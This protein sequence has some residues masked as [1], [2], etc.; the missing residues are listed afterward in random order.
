MCLVGSW[1]LDII[2]SFMDSLTLP[3]RL[4]LVDYVVQSTPPSEWTR[5]ISSDTFHGGVVQ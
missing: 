1:N 5:A 2:T 3:F 4:H